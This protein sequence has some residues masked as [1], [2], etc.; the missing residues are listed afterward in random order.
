MRDRHGVDQFQTAGWISFTPPGSGRPYPVMEHVDGVNLAGLLK[1][2]RCRSPL[3][4]SSSASC[5][6]A[7]GI[8]TRPVTRLMGDGHSKTSALGPRPGAPRHVQHGPNVVLTRRLP[9]KLHR[10]HWLSHDGTRS[11]GAN[12]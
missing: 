11:F 12:G 4:S 3:R 7:W 5:S 2:A 10:L 1:T 6:S 9:A 8:S